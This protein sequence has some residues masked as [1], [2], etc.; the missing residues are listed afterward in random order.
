M[1]IKHLLAGLMSFAL[2]P[3]TALAEETVYRISI[4]PQFTTVEI[5]KTW[6]PVLDK[7]TEL[8]G[9][10]LELLA[11]PKIPIFEQGFKSGDA[12]FAY[13]NPYHVVMANEAQGYLPLVRDKKLL[14]GILVVRKDSGITSVAQLN[15]KKIAFPAPNA[16]GASLW[17]RAQL[18]QTHGVTFEESYVGSHQTVYRQVLTGDVQA[19]GGVQ[20]TLDK[21]SASLRDELT[22]LYRTPDVPSHPIVYHPRISQQVADKFR[23]ALLSIATT[24][25]GKELL[26]AIQMTQPVATDYEQEYLP[27]KALSLE[28]F[29]K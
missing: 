3:F 24:D 18:T 15:G 7:I 20:A 12:D 5:S 11:Y 21:E 13:M 8:S 22:V 28:T 9:L 14:N 26:K 23:S 10:K 19:G 16:F 6:Q 1:K 2:L 29:V 4:V 25:E 17:M 27:L